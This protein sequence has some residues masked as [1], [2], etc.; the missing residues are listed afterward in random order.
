LEARLAP[1]AWRF[2]VIVGAVSLTAA[3]LIG[4]FATRLAAQTAA[5]VPYE[6]MPFVLYLVAAK[7]ILRKQET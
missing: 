2:L 4:P 3:T 1:A 7:L 6:N 5:A